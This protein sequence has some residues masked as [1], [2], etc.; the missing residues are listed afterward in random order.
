MNTRLTYQLDTYQ[1]VVISVSKET[2]AIS[3]LV[4]ENVLKPKDFV[5]EVTK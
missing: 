3:K 4:I 2:A 5:D 1:E